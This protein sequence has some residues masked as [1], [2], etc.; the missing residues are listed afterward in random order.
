MIT[1]IEPKL[2]D[3]FNEPIARVFACSKC[4]K[5]PLSPVQCKNPTCG[6]IF[7]GEECTKSS[8]TLCYERDS[9]KDLEG[10]LKEIMQLIYFKCPNILLGCSKI[11]F[12]KDF[13]IH[14]EKECRYSQKKVLPEKINPNE[15]LSEK[16]VRYIENGDDEE[17]VKPYTKSKIKIIDENS[18][19]HDHVISSANFN[20]LDVSYLKMIL[21]HRKLSIAGSKKELINRIEKYFNSTEYFTNSKLRMMLLDGSIEDLSKTNL[22]CLLIARDLKTGGN[23]QQQILTLKSYFIS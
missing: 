17:Y 3:K 15:F 12:Y 7:C 4:N 18:Y 21:E 20:D 10:N 5:I 1:N 9:I 11:M 2:A 14:V 16:R 23:K 6:K 13:K 22:F 8:C 19:M